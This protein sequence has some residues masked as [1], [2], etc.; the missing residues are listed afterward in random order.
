[1]YAA[2]FFGFLTLTWFSVCMVFA[3]GLPSLSKKVRVIDHTTEPLPDELESL[4]QQFVD[5][6][7]DEHELADRVERVI[8]R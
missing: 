5:G 4:K 6:D 2:A 8:D 1:M 7:L 3:V